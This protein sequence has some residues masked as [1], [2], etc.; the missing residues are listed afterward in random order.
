MLLIKILSSGF[1]C[2]GDGKAFSRC[3]NI[4]IEK[5]DILIF[6]KVKELNYT[7]YINILAIAYAF[8][9]PLSRAGISI[10]TALLFLL[11]VLDGDFKKKIAY[12]RTNNVIRVIGLFILFN[13]ISLIWTDYLYAALHYIKRYWYFAPILILF[14]SLQKEYIPKVL[15][16][17]ILGMFVSEVISYG[18]FFELWSFNH[19]SVENHSTYMH[20]I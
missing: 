8:I 3:L 14:T 17:F 19:E 6:T 12:L 7:Q 1:G 18:V 5:E 20:H 13:I 15:S 9:I 16:A 10:L 4:G 2:I 11:W